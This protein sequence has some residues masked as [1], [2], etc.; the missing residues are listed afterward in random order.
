MATTTIPAP[1]ARAPINPFGRIVGVFFSPKQTFAGIAERPSWVA[2]LLLMVVLAT[3][4][5]SL[6]NAK[7][8]WSDYIRHKAE[9]NSRFAQLSEPE[10]DRAVATQV[11]FWSGFSYVIGLVAVPLSALIFALIYWGAFNLFCGAG[12]GFGASF[13]ITTH[14]FLPTAI[15]SILAL[16]ILPLKSYGDVDPQSIVATSLHAFLPDDAPKALAALGNSLELFWIWVLV[17]L[18]IGFA[19]A[20]PKKIKL[21]ASFAIVFGLWAVW[22]LTKVAWASIM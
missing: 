3:A 16:I 10:K 8:N 15:S 19:A 5:G 11:K 1:E 7:M 14:A 18:A 9:E 12:L 20:C 22:M 6:L 4:V 21:G 17:L 2:P 13:G